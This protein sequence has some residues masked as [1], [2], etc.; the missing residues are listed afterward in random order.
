MTK[1]PRDPIKWTNQ[2]IASGTEGYLAAQAAHREDRA[3][4]EQE[5]RED[6]ELPATRRAL[7]RPVAVSVTLRPPGRRTVASRPLMQPTLPR[8]RPCTHHGAT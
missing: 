6:E 2:E 4:A 5:R 8:P 1:N 7:S 3:Q